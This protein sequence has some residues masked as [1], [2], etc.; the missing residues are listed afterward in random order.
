M[1]L[2]SPHQH[3]TNRTVKLQTVY[4]NDRKAGNPLKGRRD[5]DKEV[6]LAEDGEVLDYDNVSEHSYRF[7]VS[8]ITAEAACKIQACV[9]R[10]YAAHLYKKAILFEGCLHKGGDVEWDCKLMMKCCGATSGY[11]L[12][13]KCLRAKVCVAIKYRYF[14]HLPFP[15][16][17]VGREFPFSFRV[18]IVDNKWIDIDLVKPGTE[19]MSSAPRGDIRVGSEPLLFMDI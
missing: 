9:R 16:L 2:A 18:I 10:W 17:K 1:N 14:E 13:V 3:V 15:V 4:V 8:D 5:K 6:H 11:M 19:A 7:K 12:R